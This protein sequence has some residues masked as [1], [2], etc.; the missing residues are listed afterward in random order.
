VRNT[1]VTD[2]FASALSDR[3]FRRLYRMARLVFNRLLTALESFDYRNTRPSLVAKLS[4]TLRYLAGGSYL[5]I[6]VSHG[7]A[8]SSFIADCDELMRIIDK[9]FRIHFDPSDAERNEKNSSAFRRGSSPLFGC[10]GADDGLSIQINEPR[11]S[12]IPNPS[13]YC[14]RKGFFAIVITALC[15]ADYRFTFV[16]A[17]AP[18]STHDSIAFRMSSLNAVLES[19]ALAHGYWIVNYWQSSAKITIE[20]AFGILVG[21]WGVLWRRRRTSV[22]KSTLIIVVLAKLH[23]F[24]IENGRL[25]VV[26]RPSGIDSSSHVER[27]EM[28]VLLQDQLDNEDQ[29]HRRRRDTETSILREIVSNK[30]EINGF[31]LPVAR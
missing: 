22:A 26:P 17:I 2:E 18:G 27:A 13:S 30:I 12:E 29:L 7:V 24:I 16:S 19:G 11:G 28:A 1:F 4:M 10:V 21:R 14:N 23:N 9:A 8:V 31:R 15:D 25:P 20:Q 3:F 5:D 6:C